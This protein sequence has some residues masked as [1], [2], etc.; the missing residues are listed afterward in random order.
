MTCGRASQ[1]LSG[2]DVAPQS[3]QVAGFS[4]VVTRRRISESRWVRTHEYEANAEAYTVLQ[5]MLATKDQMPMVGT[6]I[7]SL[8]RMHEV[9]SRVS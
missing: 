4:C 1:T 9:E 5:R 8:C 2:F 6:Y 7:D 3:I